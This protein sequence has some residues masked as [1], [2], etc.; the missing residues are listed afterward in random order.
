MHVWGITH[1][2]AVRQQ[3]QDAFASQVLED[4]RVVQC[5]RHA[6][7]L[8]EDGP[9]AGLWNAQQKLEHY[10]KQEVSA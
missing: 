5:G 6:A 9:Y 8:A 4:G 7:L 2:G 10:T 3:N 1:K